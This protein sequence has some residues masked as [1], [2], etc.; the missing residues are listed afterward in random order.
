MRGLACILKILNIFVKKQQNL[1]EKLIYNDE[2]DKIHYP[3]HHH[4]HH[5]LRIPAAVHSTAEPNGSI[6]N[7]MSIDVNMYNIS[8]CSSCSSCSILLILLLLLLLLSLR[9]KKIKM[10]RK[11]CRL[12]FFKHHHRIASHQNTR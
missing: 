12:F 3:H 2:D 11:K 9:L 4:H 1:G 10:L 8:C 5:H 6:Y 7:L